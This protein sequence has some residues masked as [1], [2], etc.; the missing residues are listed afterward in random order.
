MADVFVSYKRENEAKVAKLVAA[1]EAQGLD[2]WWDR[3]IEPGAPWE[4]SIEKQLA[5]ARAV[6]VC[7]SKEAVASENV[8]SEARLARN[9]GRLIQVF[10]EQCEPPLFFGERQGIDLKNWRGSPD[11]PQIARLAGAARAI[12]EGNPPVELT[13]VPPS[14]TLVTRRALIASLIALMLAAMAGWFVLREAAPAGPTTLAVLPFRALSAADANLSDAIADDTRSAIGRNPNL[15]VVGRL[16]VTAL[17]QQGL[18]PQDFRKRL[19]ADYLL[20]GSVQ[21]NGQLLRIKVSLVRA[22]DATEVWADQL[23]GKVDDVFTFQGR[24]ARE[25]EGRIRGRLAPNEGKKAENITTTGEVYAIFAEAR[26]HAH[27]RN[28]DDGAQALDLL[29]KAV[30]MDPNFAP[31]WAELGAVTARRGATPDKSERQ[32]QAE[33]TTYLTRALALAPNLAL[34]HGALAMANGFPP[35]LEPE[36]LKAVAL[37]PNDADLWNWLGNSYVGQN[38]MREA[39]GA[40]RRANEI[41][42]LLTSSLGNLF[43]GLV[44][45]REEEGIA[46]VLA[47]V[48]RTGDPVL[49]TKARF[50]L[51]NARGK[52]GDALRVGLSL[53][54]EHPE[55]KGYIEPR[56]SRSL[57]QLGFVAEGLEAI[58]VG[59]ER[60]PDFLGVPIPASVIR[61]AYG[62]PEDLWDDGGYPM[63]M[64]RTL[65]KSGRL[66]EFVGYYNSAFKRPEDFFDFSPSGN[67]GK[68][69]SFAPNVAVLLRAAGQTKDAD[70]ILNLNERLIA[71]F[72]KNGPPNDY[73]VNLAQLRAAQGRDEDVVPLLSKA[74]AVGWLPDRQLEAVDIVDEPCFARLVNRPD[75][76]ALRKRILARIEEERRIAAPAIASAHL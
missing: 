66:K 21:R 57:I 22:K 49:A 56:I 52:V 62:T 8:R 41:D 60:V 69:R 36:L 9:Q 18:T 13:A 50:W 10:L 70:E 53:M 11:D 16:A 26:A 67:K 30:T 74:V 45:L 32:G 4:A 54:T 1:L 37:D 72:L 59:A 15:R 39:V 58:R 42:P 46:D 51:A 17:A 43:G 31:A 73:Y 14:R 61:S 40:F 6:I 28:R 33:A 68:Y 20:D 19:G 5:N 12:A 29:K 2:A 24:I 25:V 44:E 48:D 34:A 23:D 55:E 71:G 3:E 35:E 64:A 27:K 7:W 76:Q 38:K 65:P 63:L 47:R 75:F